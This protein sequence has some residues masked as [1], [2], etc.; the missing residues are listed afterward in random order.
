MPL[1]G[2]RYDDR[3]TR[4]VAAVAELGIRCITQV[5]HSKIEKKRAIALEAVRDPQ[6]HAR[7]YAARLS[8]APCCADDMHGRR[9]HEQEKKRLRRKRKTEEF[10]LNRR[11]IKVTQKARDASAADDDK[12]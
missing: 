2:K 5:V 4:G 10:S 12:L 6:Q 8:I 9:M 7:R 3:V 1:F 11:K